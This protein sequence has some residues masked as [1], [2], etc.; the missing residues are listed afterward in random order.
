MKKLSSVAWTE[1]HKKFLRDNYLSMND[2]ELAAAVANVQPSRKRTK[3]AVKAELSKLECFRP[4]R[5][6]AQANA[7]NIVQPRIVVVGN[8]TIHRCFA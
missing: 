7:E 4:T 6:Q 2:T 8:K 1:Q 3:H 5:K